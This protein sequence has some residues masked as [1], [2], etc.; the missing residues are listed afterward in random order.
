[1]MRLDLQP[2]A[3]EAALTSSPA[4]LLPVLATVRDKRAAMMFVDQDSGPFALPATAKLAA[5]VFIGDDMHVSMGP[6]GFHL[7]SIRRLIRA[8]RAFAVVSSA[9]NANLYGSMAAVAVGGGHAL[10]VETRLEHEFQ[11]VALIQKLA[12]HRP[13]IISTV[14]GGQA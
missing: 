13:L 9:P 3:I 12:P 14:K 10:V 8:C 1:M 5:T 2:A 6:D 11:W 7:P 4:H